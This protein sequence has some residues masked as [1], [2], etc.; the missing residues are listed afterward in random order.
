M[1]SDEDNLRLAEL[2]PSDDFGH[3]VRRVPRALLVPT[4]A[5]EVVG[6]VERARQE[7]IPVVARGRGHSV[8]GQS[9]VE[10]GWVVDMSGLGGIEITGR[11]ARVGAGASWSDVLQVTL[12][13]GLAPPVLTDYTGLSVG[14]TLSVGGIG[15]SSFS[16]GAQVDQV[17][18]LTLVTG[19]GEL[20]VCSLQHDRDLFDSARAGLGQVGIITHVQLRLV[21]APSHVRHYRIPHATLDSLLADLDRLTHESYQQLSAVGTMD[22][23][24]KW[25]F[26]IDAVRSFENGRPPVDTGLDPAI[27]VS[28]LSSLEYATRLHGAVAEWHSSGLWA[29]PHPWVDVFVPGAALPQ[30]AQRVVDALGPE[31]LGVEGAMILIYPIAIREDAAPLLPIPGRDRCAYLFDVLRCVPGA[32]AARVDALLLANRAI[33]E[34]ALALGGSLYPISAVAMSPADWRRHFGGRWSDFV[35]AKRRYDPDFILGRGCGIFSAAARDG[36]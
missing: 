11:T 24:G 7:A 10:G 5:G 16:F 34:Q 13:R 4:T 26:H 29:A 28:D 6:I 36:D 2:D 25:S 22:L 35:A 21:D 18:A 32:D 30:L 1:N 31:D 15:G 14:G 8:F 23:A 9:Q 20:R 19:A 3:I 12:A 27:V 17:E 33:Y